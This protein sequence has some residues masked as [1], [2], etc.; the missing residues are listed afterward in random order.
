MSNDFAPRVS[1][2]VPSDWDATLLD[3]AGAFPS[4]RDFVLSHWSSGDARGMHAMGVLLRHP[5]LAKAFLAFNNHIATASTLPKR[6]REL[7]ILRISWLRHSEYEYTQHL[8]LGRRAGLSEL[9]LTRIQEG[10]AA[11]GWDPVDSALLRAVDELHVGAW[12]KPGTWEQL[13]AHFDTH[14]LMD[15]VFTVGCFEVLAMAFNTMGVQLEAG[16][17]PLDP[18]VRAR[19]HAVSQG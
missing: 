17:E 5:A 16:A 18:S 1:P 11:P 2:V 12:I 9:E 13:A 14:Q 6:I 4:G 3:A 19:L 15:V 7:L 10:A 8:V